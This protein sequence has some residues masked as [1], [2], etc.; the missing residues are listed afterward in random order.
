MPNKEGHRRF[1]DVRKLPSGRY[2]V[3][4]PGPG[5]RIRTAPE[6]YARKQDAERHLVLVETQMMRQEWTDPARAKVSIERTR[7]AGSPS[8]R[9]SG[10]GPWSC[11]RGCS[12]STSRRTWAASSLAGSIR[13]WFG[14]GGRS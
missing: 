4:Y 9:T 11:T 2:Q 7:S 6:T 1:G 8:G 13:R 5:G 12:A 10:R 3:R 14:S